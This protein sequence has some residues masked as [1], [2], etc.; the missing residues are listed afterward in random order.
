MK[1]FGRTLR[2]LAVRHPRG[3]A[4][5]LQVSF[6]LLVLMGLLAVVI[7]LGIA[8]ASQTFLQ[9]GADAA[10]LEGLRLRDSIPGDPVGSDLTRRMAAS[11]AASLVYDEDLDPMTGPDAF[12]LGAGPQF[13]TGVQGVDMPAGGLLVG[14]G[15]YLPV[16]QDNVTANEVHGD[17]VA[18]T[19]TENPGAP[20]WHAETSA[21]L[22][23]DF[24]PSAAAD[25]PTSDAFLARIRRTNDLQGLD[26]QPRI[27]SSGPTLPFLFGLGSGVLTTDD[28]N[29]YDPRRDGI[30][31]RATSIAD[32]R[33]VVAAGVKGPLVNGIGRVGTDVAVPTSARVLAIEGGSWQSDFVTEA[34]FEIQVFDDGTILGSPGGLTPSAE[35]YAYAVSTW[36]RVGDR[37][38]PSPVAGSVGFTER[39]VEGLCYVALY[40]NTGGPCG[41]PPLPGVITG[42]AAVFVDGAVPDPGGSF[43][44]VTGSKLR[45][46]VAPENASAIGALAFDLN[47]LQADGLDREPLRAPVLAR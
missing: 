38:C 14:Q 39:D 46:Q 44:S 41:S 33:P 22:R 45:S 37:F 15:P 27:S 13:E 7:D 19:F 17:L 16:L 25:S 4:I 35:G 24:A 30:T 8:R 34:G 18:G 42:F 12:V 47:A 32:A 31:I 6:L 2:G 3:G 10:A 5:L 26:N 36:A 43:L 20:Q 23:T 9:A 21:Y 29:V 28:A 40:A 1:A 11:R